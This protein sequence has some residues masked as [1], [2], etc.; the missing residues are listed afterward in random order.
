[1]TVTDNDYSSDS[2]DGL[3]ANRTTN[4]QGASVSPSDVHREKGNRFITLGW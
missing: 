4:R 3:K 1:M 2:D